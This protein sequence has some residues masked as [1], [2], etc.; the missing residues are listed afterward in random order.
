MDHCLWEEGRNAFLV[1]FTKNYYFK[2]KIFPP[3][4]GFDT[5]LVASLGQRIDTTFPCALD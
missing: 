5:L 4:G 1:L 3:F 2:L